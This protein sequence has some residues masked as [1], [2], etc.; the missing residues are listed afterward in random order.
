MRAAQCCGGE[1]LQGC[2]LLCELQDEALLG[3]TSVLQRHRVRVC[4]PPCSLLSQ[5]GNLS[6]P[7]LHRHLQISQNRLTL[8]LVSQASLD[9]Y[10]VL[11]P[12]C[13]QGK[14]RLMLQCYGTQILDRAAGPLSCFV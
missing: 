11:F 4:T 6:F 3:F 13:P 8:Q 14:P 2:H 12:V 1:H 9:Q 7:P 5:P 10:C